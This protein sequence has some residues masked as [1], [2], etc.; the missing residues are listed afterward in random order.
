MTP[1]RDVPPESVEQWVARQV[2]SAPPLT[3]EQRAVIA[4]ALRRT[5]ADPDQQRGRRQVA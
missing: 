1:A 5:V 2:A 4:G 3:A